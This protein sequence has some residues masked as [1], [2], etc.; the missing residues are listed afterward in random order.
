MAAGAQSDHPGVLLRDRLDFGIGR[1]PGNETLR[2]DDKENAAFR[3][4]SIRDSYAGER[5]PR[6]LRTLRCSIVNRFTQLTTEFMIKPV[7]LPSGVEISSKSC[8]GSTVREP[9]S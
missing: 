3:H 4:F 5:R 9:G 2:H 1:D 7:C 8:V 6:V